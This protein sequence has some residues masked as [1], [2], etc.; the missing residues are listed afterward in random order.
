MKAEP[1]VKSACEDWAAEARVPADLADRALRARPGAVP[2]GW[3]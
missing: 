3:R 2:S 1:I